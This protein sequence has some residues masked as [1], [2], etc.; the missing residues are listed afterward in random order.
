MSRIITPG[1]QSFAKLRIN[2]YFY[3]NKTKFIKYCWHDGIDVTLIT[4]LRCFGKTLI[5]DTVKTFFLP[6][7]SGRDDIFA[8]LD[9]WKDNEIRRFQCSIPVVFVSF[10]EIN[11]TC[12]GAVSRIKASLANIYNEF[13]KFIDL[14]IISQT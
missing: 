6:E 14:N 10:A 4:R 8:G 9:I 12:E 5:L 1:T 13:F 11:N 7:F 3:I 2:N